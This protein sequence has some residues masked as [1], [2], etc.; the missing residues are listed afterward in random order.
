M[1]LRR[2]YERRSNIILEVY[3][4]VSARASM[5]RKDRALFEKRQ[6]ADAVNS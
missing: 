3:S 5:G 4:P 2:A 6:A 1:Q